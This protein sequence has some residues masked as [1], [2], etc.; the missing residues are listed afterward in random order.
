MPQGEQARSRA[1]TG[2]PASPGLAHGPAAVWPE[3]TVAIP[4]RTGCRREVERPRLDAARAAA[5]EEIRGLRDKI[6]AEAGQVEA[7]IFDAHLMFLDDTALL[8]KAEAAIDGGLNGEAAWMDAVEQF[9]SQLDALP[10]PTLRARAADIRDVG[11]RVLDHMLGR[12]AAKGLDLQ[13]PS[14][15]VARDLAPS[16]I[17]SLNV[18]RVLAFCTAEGGPTSHTAI[19]AKAWGL[20]AV[21][22]LGQAI[23]DVADSTLLLVDGGR[24]EVIADPD[25]TTIEVFKGRRGQAARRAQVELA[26]A[27]E[28]AVTR[29]GRRAE[30]VANIGAVDEAA[31]A[32]ELGA[33]GIGLLRTEFLYLGRKTAPD[34][35][36]QLA[37]YNA[38][39]DAMD[40]RPVVVRTLDAGGDKEL[41]YLNLGRE[42]NP[43]LGWRAIRIS[44]GRPE[45]FKVQLRALLRA[46]PGHD[47]RIM[48]PMIAT[49]EE[50]R[51]AKAVLEE[52]RGE[53]RAAG[54]AVAA[55]IQVG[56]MVEVP[57]VVILADLFAREVDFFSIGTND[58]T[59]YTM[60]ADRANEKVAYLGDS[61]HPAVLRQVQRVIEAGHQAG[62]WV[63]VCG[64][65]ASDPDAVP[66]LLGLGLDEFSMVPPA[67][68]RAKAIIRR[69][70]MA[71]ARR[72]A[73]D[74][75]TLESAEVVREIVRSAQPA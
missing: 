31:P 71:G 6:A 60:A 27:R 61:C 4:R 13:R 69:W 2:L 52:A 22:G 12:G 33:E 5:R 39:L 74:V 50:V 72:L 66:V 9:A 11:R 26:S 41:P 53:V 19:L 32:L 14:V 59:Q 42:A 1:L 57:S 70:S 46:S 34:E 48:F 75:L 16:Q 64:E 18:S 38:V 62:I 8:T 3:E 65:L 17:A 55:S 29:D 36:E 43:F 45:V 63:G 20:P 49:L 44:L 54:H 47:L 35:E 21:V 7:A 68:P 56:I 15:V 37:A 23:L 28:P 30:V 73:A 10:D 25:R 51:Q 40:T 58:L 24:G 67:I